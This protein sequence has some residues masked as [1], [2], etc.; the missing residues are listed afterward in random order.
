[1]SLNLTSRDTFVGQAV[2]SKK[3]FAP[4]VAEGSTGGGRGDGREGYKHRGSVAHTL[5]RDGF[6]RFVYS[7]RPL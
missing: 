2:G 6:S 5:Q 3:C 1:M 7:L 4:N